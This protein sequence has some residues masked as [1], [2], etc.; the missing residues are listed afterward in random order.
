[1]PHCN[2]TDCRFCDE[3]KLLCQT[4]AYLVERRCITFKRRPR[5][6]NYRE[7]M[8]KESPNCH[9]DGGGKYRSSRVNLVK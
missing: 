8:R 7:L 2:Q 3:T 9:K 4:E 1:M 5:G 6:E